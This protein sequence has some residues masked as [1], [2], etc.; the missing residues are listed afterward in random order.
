M[1]NIY[2]IGASGFAKEV[3][4]LLKDLNKYKI[5]GFIDKTPKNNTIEIGN[6]IIDIIDEDYF[7]NNFKNC[8]V[9]IGIGTPKIIHKIKEKYKNYNF[10]NLIH[11][12]FLGDSENILFGVGNIITAGV[13][14]TT[15][16]KI[17]N[18]NIFNLNTTIGH[19][20]KIGD[21]NIFNPSTNISGNCNI[22]NNNLFGVGTIILENLN[23][24]SNNIIGA[25][26]VAIKCIDKDSTYVGVPC[27]K[28]K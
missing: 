15:N 3:Y 12:S 4:W 16:I 27:K 10:P 19:D 1:D 17:G 9:C 8:S 23:V 11:P 21:S 18:F 2:I 5:C 22:E 7:L 20:V 25:G 14:F 26:S 28:I 24:G 6:S 13:V